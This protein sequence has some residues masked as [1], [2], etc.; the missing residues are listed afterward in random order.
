MRTIVIANQKGGCGKTT[1]AINLAASFARSRSRVL[2]V[3][4]DP[5]AHATLGLGVEPENLDVTT[6][7]VLNRRDMPISSALVPASAKGLNL[8]P[9]SILLSG[10]E[11]ELASLRG[12]EYV[13][14]ERLSRLN[15][16][17]DICIIDCSPSLSLLTVNA[18]VAGDDVIVPVQVH[19]YALEG[20][21]QLLKT[22]DIVRDRFNGSLRILGVLLTFVEG[23]TALSRDVQEQMRNYFGDLVFKT[24]IHKNVKLA[25]APSAG[26]CV[27]DYAPG[28][29]AAEEYRALAREISCG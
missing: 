14:K 15:G 26:K 5:Q 19:Y 21:K 9:G 13:L 25:E 16:S 27:L 20:L 2:I 3:D 23:S 8:S 6:Y 7:D 1:T 17:F 10:L 28:G 29:R 18:L 4:L 22:M 12:R 24:V 11:L